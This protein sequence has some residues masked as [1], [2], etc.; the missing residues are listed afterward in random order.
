MPIEG[1]QTDRQWKLP[2]L[3]LH[4]FSDFGGPSKLI[5]SS[6]ASLMLQGL[7]PREQNTEAELEQ[8]LL[9]G[10][11]CEVRMLFY[12]GK[13][14]LRWME[15][16]LEMVERDEHLRDKGI[17]RQSLVALL[18]NDPPMH[19]AEKLQSWGVVDY[20]AIFSRAIGLNMVFIEVP[21][22]EL[23]PS[24]FVRN[25]YRFADSLYNCYQAMQPF[26]QI[27]A[28]NFDFDLFAS[29]EYSRLLER[30]WQES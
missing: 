12:V 5:E 2:P 8:I 16:C 11:Y 7:L 29:G 10:R 23:I 4:P 9:D 30:E 25:Y 1:L 21:D 18:V 13:D 14:L 3:I 24:E 28:K 22:P 6:R 26:T 27:K 19:V 15:Q 17:I 20:A